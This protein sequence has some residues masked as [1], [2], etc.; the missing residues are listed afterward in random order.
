MPYISITPETDAKRLQAKLKEL[1]EEISSELASVDEEQGK[2]LLSDFVSELFLA[3]A[4][5]KQ[6]KERRQRQAEGISA[7]KAR[8]VRFGR[9]GRALPDNFDEI[10]LAWRD[11]QMSLQ[12]AADA[13]GMAKGTFYGI[14]TRREKAEG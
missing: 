14:A 11:G 13:C 9:T 10:H 7:A 5:Q 12:Q 6:K 3:T 4:E 8:G 2:S 1:A